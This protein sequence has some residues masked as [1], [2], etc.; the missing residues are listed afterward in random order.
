[1]SLRLFVFVFCKLET[2][3]SGSKQH[4]PSHSSK[5]TSG[6]NQYANSKDVSRNKQIL[7]MGVSIY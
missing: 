6:I 5:K 3:D 1:M 2:A 7:L 4:N